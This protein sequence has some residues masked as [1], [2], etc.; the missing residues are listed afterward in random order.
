MSTE[1][2]KKA[3]A[4]I[5]EYKEVDESSISLDTKLKDLEM[6]SLDALNLIFELEELSLG[7]CRSVSDSGV[8]TLSVAWVPCIVD[9]SGETTAL[10]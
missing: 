8:R 2:S 1:V 6:D 5:A 10:I 7:W 9:E 4:V 3:I